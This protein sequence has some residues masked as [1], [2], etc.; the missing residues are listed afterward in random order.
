M[1]LNSCAG[2]GVLCRGNAKMRV[3]YNGPEIR[4][5]EKEDEAVY[6]PR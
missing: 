3:I 2:K 6:V 1:A 5:T 4:R